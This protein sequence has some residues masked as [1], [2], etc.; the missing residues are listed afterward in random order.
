MAFQ[1]P[2]EN[3]I[4]HRFSDLRGRRHEIKS[5]N[6]SIKDTFNLEYIYKALRIWGLQNGWA[7]WSDQDFQELWY[8]HRDHPTAG[9]EMRIR[10]R[11]EKKPEDKKL[12]LYRMDLDH[13]FRG[14]KDVE[15]P[16]RGQKIKAQRGEFE[17]DCVVYIIVDPENA[18]EKSILKPFRDLFVNRIVKNRFDYHKKFI[19]AESLKFRDFI[20]NYFKQHPYFPVKE[21]GEFF[22][23]RDVT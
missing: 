1:Q 5:W 9:K 15:I 14:I 10:W 16:W 2:I 8:V 23:K 19:D 12:F 18:W 13:H 7:P 3:P 22:A 20:F 6:I 4:K 21:G 11:W 17:M